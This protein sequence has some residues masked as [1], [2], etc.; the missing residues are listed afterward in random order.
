MNKVSEH[1]SWAD[2]IR[3]ET[4]KKLGIKN[5]F[6]VEQ[7]ERMTSLANAVYE[8][9][10]NHFKVLIYISSFFRCK[11]LNDL[12]GGAAESQHL[13]NN[14]AAID[15]DADSNEGITNKEVFDYIKDNLE[16]DQLIW[17]FGTK[18]NPDWVHVSY[19]KGKNRKEILRSVRKTT[20]EITY[21]KYK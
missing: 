10:Y 11:K 16:F 17:E 1:I 5:Y 9:L 20:Q 14:G 21:E 13:A 4:A 3:S 18:K 8:P 15:L 7:L 2:A 6:T 12:L 19:N